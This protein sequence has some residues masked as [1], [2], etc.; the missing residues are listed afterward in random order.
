MPDSIKGI[1]LKVSFENVMRLAQRSAGSV[2]LK[3][4]FATMGELWSAAKAAGV[5]DPIRVFD[6]DKAARRYADLNQFPA[7]CLFTEDEV[8]Q[9]D[10]AR[11]QAKQQAQAPAMAMA[12][13]TAARTLS[14][15]QLPNAPGGN[16][17]AALVGG[18]PGG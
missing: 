15:T 6:L 4:T 13:V 10:A 8:K 7:D 17:L 2:A 1:A 9:H 18:G 12:G 5:P 11:E 16:A 14:Q 3:D